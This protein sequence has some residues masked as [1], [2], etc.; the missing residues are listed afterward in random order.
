MTTPSTLCPAQSHSDL[1]ECTHNPT[2]PDDDDGVNSM[3]PHNGNDNACVRE[4]KTTALVFASG[5]IVVMDA[6]SKNDSRLA[7]CNSPCRLVLRVT[8]QPDVLT[9]MWIVCLRRTVGADVFVQ[10]SRWIPFSVLR[11]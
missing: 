1:L 2:C 5:K 4:S 11:I 9:G 10:L 3:P 8:E 7:S 6:K